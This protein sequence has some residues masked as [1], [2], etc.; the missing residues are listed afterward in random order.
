MILRWSQL[1]EQ[2]QDHGVTLETTDL[3]ILTE[4]G[5]R[6]TTQFLVRWVHG[7]P[8]YHVVE[9]ENFSD[10]VPKYLPRRIAIA[11]G[12]PPDLFILPDDSL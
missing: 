1:L 9:I 7:Q 3:E 10:P 5:E 8:R 4:T 6:M 12:L 2:L 11:L